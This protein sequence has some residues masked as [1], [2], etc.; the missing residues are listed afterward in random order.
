MNDEKEV[1]ILATQLLNEDTNI[2]VELLEDFDVRGFRNEH[3]KTSSIRLGPR[4]RFSSL[5]SC[6]DINR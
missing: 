4:L 5:N 3:S 2:P 6:P 1:G